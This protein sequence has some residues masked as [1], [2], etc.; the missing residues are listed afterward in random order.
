M[1]IYSPSHIIITLYN[2]RPDNQPNELDD[3][4]DS[5][6]EE[7]VARKAR[8]NSLINDFVARGTSVFVSFYIE[9]GGNNCDIL[10]ISA[11]CFTLD[12]DTTKSGEKG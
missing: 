7:A 3:L 5:E 11:E 4:Y 2:N 6:P 1:T 8:K 10:Q 9:T 12:Y